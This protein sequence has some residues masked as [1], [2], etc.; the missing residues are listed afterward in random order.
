MGGSETIGRDA[1]L[2]FAEQRP[3]EVSVVIEQTEGSTG[4]VS[5]YVNIAVELAT[6]GPSPS[7]LILRHIE[8]R[9]LA[10]R[11]SGVTTELSGTELLELYYPGSRALDVPDAVDR[12][13]V[14]RARDFGPHVAEQ[15]DD[16][17]WARFCHAAYEVWPTKDRKE[18]VF[19]FTTASITL[20]YM[21]DCLNESHDDPLAAVRR[22]QRRFVAFLTDLNEEMLRRVT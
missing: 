21:V 5:E 14:E 15:L 6:D 7:D 4:G 9:R 19:D 20:K 1:M 17:A 16:D 22:R 12:S 13:I 3:Q 11:N 18:A 10:E 2:E 8:I